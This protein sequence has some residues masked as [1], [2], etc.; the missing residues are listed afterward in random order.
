ME[1]H[2]K[3]DDVVLYGDVHPST[4]SYLVN[5]TCE[6]LQEATTGRIASS[7][8]YWG[9]IQYARIGH[10]RGCR[11]RNFMDK[12]RSCMGGAVLFADTH[13]STNIQSLNRTCEH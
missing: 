3:L 8:E 11:C 7:I 4:V 6:N 9:P 2:A 12:L 13:P 1:K 5:R 10:A